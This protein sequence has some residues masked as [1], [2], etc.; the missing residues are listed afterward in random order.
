MDAEIIAIGSEL[1]LGAT[2]DTNSTYLASQLA[3]AGVNV[4]RKSVV[5][6]NV[7]RITALIN[8][9]LSRADLV[10]CTGGLGPTQDDVTREAV[11]QAFGQPLEF[12]QELL[13]QVA[14]RFAAFRRT[15]SPSN[16]RQAYL[17]QGARAIENPRGTAPAF[18]IEDERG[19]VIGLP[20]VPSEMRFLYETVVQPYLRTERGI[21]DVI[22]T[23]TL[24]ATGLGE[25]VIG[26]RIADLMDQANPTVGISAKAARYELRIGA[27][28]ERVDAAEA[29]IAGVEATLRDRLGSYLIGDEPLEKLVPRLLAERQCSLAIYE[30]NAFAPVY[31]ALGVRPEGLARLRGVTIHPLDEPADETGAEALA[32]SGATT[33][34]NRWRSDLAIGVQAATHP[35]ESGFTAVSV[36]L[37]AL[38]TTR[39][40]TRHF[41]LRQVEGWG[42]VGTLGL[43]MLRR[44]LL[45]E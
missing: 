27:R 28:A 5:G 37:I 21:R 12:R 31:R 44:Y 14:A 8:E 23:R 41:D 9:S 3:A 33:A 25:S 19:T 40:V 29:L 17:P 45:G 1:L 36:V 22:L 35:N 10:I 11:A 7:G 32:R 34:M 30:G 15:M 24:Y 42:F 26:E 4:F 38:D 20:G 43:E 39:H 2:V 18:L 16:R 6:D 13:D